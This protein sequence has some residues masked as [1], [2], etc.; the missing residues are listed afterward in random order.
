MAVKPESPKEGFAVAIGSKTVNE[1]E[2]QRQRV[3]RHYIFH[4][5]VQHCGFRMT[6]WKFAKEQ[7]IT[8]WVFNRTDGCVEMEAQGEPGRLWLFKSSIMGLQVLITEIEETELPVRTDEEWYLI[9]R[10]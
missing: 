10:K 9:L 4:G 3:R 5:R 1:A 8:G 7:H 6:S 2:L